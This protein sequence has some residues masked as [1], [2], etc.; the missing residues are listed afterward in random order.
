MKQKVLATLSLLAV[1]GE[2]SAAPFIRRFT[3]HARHNEDALNQFEGRLSWRQPNSEDRTMIEQHESATEGN[4][5]NNNAADIQENCEDPTIV[6]KVMGGESFF[7][8]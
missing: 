5:W 3:N 8:F 6:T 7:F 2:G 4:N 1:I